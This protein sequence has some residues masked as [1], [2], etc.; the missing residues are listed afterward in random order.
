M[1]LMRQVVMTVI[2][3]VK[4]IAVRIKAPASIMD[5]VFSCVAADVGCYQ[6]GSSW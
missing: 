5:R 2:R 4:M 3:V 1:M 6:L